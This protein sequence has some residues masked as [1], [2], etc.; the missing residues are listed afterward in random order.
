MAKVIL[1]AGKVG[2]A[3]IVP[4][5]ILGIALLT[6][7]YFSV[8]QAELQDETEAIPLQVQQL[9]QAA[10]TYI[11]AKQYD[12]AE[13]SYLDIVDGFPGTE[14]ALEALG[15]LGRFYAKQSD[16][17]SV[18]VV[19]DQLYS[20]Y[21]TQPQVTRVIDHIAE[22]YIKYHT[23]KARAI[24][25]ESITQM[26]GHPDVAWLHGASIRCLITQENF[27]QAQ[28]AIE[29]LLNDYSEY[30]DLCAIVNSL[31]KTSLNW[32]KFDKA[33]DLYEYVY[34]NSSDSDLVFKALSGIADC[35]FRL[36]NYSTA[37]QIIDTLINE[38]SENPGLCA[39][40]CG[41]A[42]QYMYS[43]K[44]DKAGD[45]YQYVSQNSSDSSLT[46]KGLKGVVC[47]ES[48]LGNYTVAEQAQNELFSYS[49]HDDFGKSVYRLSNQLRQIDQNARA[50][51]IVSS[52]LSEN[53]SADNAFQ[54][55]R[56][57][58]LNSLA[59]GELVM[60]EDFVGS[61]MQT[62]SDLGLLADPNI[63]AG[64]MPDPNS[65][66]LADDVLDDFDP[67][68]QIFPVFEEF[69]KQASK[70]LRNGRPVLA[71]QYFKR[72]IKLGKDIDE[73]LPAFKKDYLSAE[74][75]LMIA[76]SYRH[77]GQY[78]EAISYLQ[79]AIN[80]WPGNKYT[81]QAEFVLKDCYKRLGTVR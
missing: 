15:Q 52:Y 20:E 41:F 30:S 13:Q 44:F 66:V 26:S 6:V 58:A 59:V 29:I 48:Q 74:V 62:M 53:P 73:K 54:L 57:I 37:D 64:T 72:A 68:K 81:S 28:Q 11:A 38:Y 1:R 12:L 33:S 71:R 80:K 10:A 49:N 9:Q 16:D 23:A 3:I 40:L 4:L 25:A 77:E 75:C 27:T 51:E 78:S 39:K 32:K 17:V 63:P 69:Y 47:C 22:G 36:G 43:K 70:Q 24:Y 19:V 56:E 14:Y 55:R 35:Q 60:V 67:A 65:S 46:I 21:S 45:Y 34:L 79:K 61:F 5:V 8:A 42:D 7:N 18:K 2:L 50:I 76:E 31:A